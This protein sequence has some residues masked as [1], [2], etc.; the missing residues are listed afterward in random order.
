MVVSEHT[1]GLVEVSKD[2]VLPA[3]HQASWT[4]M[5]VRSKGENPALCKHGPLRQPWCSISFG[6][7]YGTILEHTPLGLRIAR[8]RTSL[9]GRAGSRLPPNIKASSL[10]LQ[11]LCKCL[12][13]PPPLYHPYNKVFLTR[14]YPSPIWGFNFDS[15]LMACYFNIHFPLLTEVQHLLCFNS[16]TWTKVY[17]TTWFLYTLIPLL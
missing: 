3:L 10:V 12:A 17:K 16:P 14:D 2:L 13:H 11:Q 15:S 9:T 4:L 1:P 5:W 8:I 7:G 6:R